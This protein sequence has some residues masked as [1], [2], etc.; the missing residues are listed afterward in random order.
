MPAPDRQAVAARH[1]ERAIEFLRQGG[2]SLVTTKVESLF[3]WSRKY[4]MFLYPFVI[5]I[6]EARR[7]E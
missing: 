5:R 6:H 7:A 2:D 1:S 3:N 4:S